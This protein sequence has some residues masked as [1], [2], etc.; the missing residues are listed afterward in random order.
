MPTLNSQLFADCQALQVRDVTLSATDDAQS[1]REKL[2]R[3]L[4]DEMHQFVG[5]LDSKGNILDVNRA[6][7]ERAG[8]QLDDVQGKPFWEARWWLASQAIQQT[9]R[10]L[11]RRAS[12]GEFIRCEMEIFARAAGEET[13]V[14]DYSLSP[15]K[16]RIGRI[17]FLLAEG[18]N[19]TDG[20]GS[21]DLQSLTQELI[22]GRERLRE[23]DMALEGL[24]ELFVVVDRNYRY[25]IVNR[26]FLKYRAVEREQLVGRAIADFLDPEVEKRV[27]KKLDECFEG[28]VVVFEQKIAYPHL[29]ERDLLTSYFPIEG[30]DGVDRVACILQDITERRKAEAALHQLSGRLQRLE[31]EERRRLA[32]ALHDSTAQQLSALSMNLFVVNEGAAALSP[33]AQ[34][35]LSESVALLDACVREIRT[36]SY[37]LHPP[38][39]DKL[40]LRRAL[41]RYADGFGQRSGIQV[42]LNASADVGSLPLNV[43]TTIFRIVQECLTNIHRHS[44]SRTASICLRRVASDLVV[45]VQDAGT[46]MRSDAHAG[47]GIASMQERLQELGEIGRASCRERVW[48][49]V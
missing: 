1:H 9:Q 26:A 44:G 24:E 47:V 15:V 25:Q 30:P 41:A 19:L 16:D 2:A 6:A 49:P 3:I 17:V 7:L 12:Q 29:G 43:E 31:D 38:Q 35:A 42:E 32:R 5:L 20:R 22:A 11:V 10:D 39:L 36:V 23:Y 4:L 8:I 14:I 37:L 28:K 40:G 46:G 45:E 34:R 13:T 21:R 18:R 48:I 33:R 27:R